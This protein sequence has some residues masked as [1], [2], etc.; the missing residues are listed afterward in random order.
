MKYNTRF[1]PS[2]SG[3]LHIGHLYMALV[4]EAEAHRTGGKFIVRVDDMQPQINHWLKKDKRDYYYEEYQ[5][6]LDIFMDVD[7]WDL[8][9]QML[10][11]AEIIGDNPILRCLPEFL[12]AS[13]ET[14]EWRIN[15]DQ[16]A[17]QYNLC[18]VV[19]KVIWDF[20]EGV[21]LLIR[22][23][24][25]ITESQLYEHITSVLRLP[26]IRQIYLPK[27]VS[28]TLDDILPEISKSKKSYSLDTQINEF[29]IDR[30]LELLKK[31]CLIDPDGWF[32]ADNIK[33]NPI[34][35]GFK[36]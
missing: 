33:S 27:L 2:I 29:G 16:R 20:W 15:T 13:T 26:T 7:V 17:F 3:E 1:N 22:G 32:F 6:Q 30:T 9:S 31:A 21:T 12:W 25:L 10:T 18:F 19:E 8:Q 5:K 28:I 23:E 35:K 36:E 14:I 11:P 24:D 4:N 34:A